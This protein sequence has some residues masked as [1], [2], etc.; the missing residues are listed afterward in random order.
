[1]RTGSGIASGIRVVEIG[2]SAAVAG[3]GMVLA[4]AGADVLLLEAPGGSA[5]REEPAF[6]MW[7]RGKRSLV[8]DLGDT[9][10]RERAGSP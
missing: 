1:M 4:D 7:A 8:A 2:S 10:G 3:A 5:L 6:A 9:E